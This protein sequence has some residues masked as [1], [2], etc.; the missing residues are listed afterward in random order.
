M[1]LDVSI[2]KSVG[3][4]VQGMFGLRTLLQDHASES[5]IHAITLK[6]SSL[7]EDYRAEKSTGHFAPCFTLI[8]QKGT[9][10]QLEIRAHGQ[11]DS[12]GVIPLKAKEHQGYQQLELIKEDKR[13]KRKPIKRVANGIGRSMLVLEMVDIRARLS[14]TCNDELNRFLDAKTSFEWSFDLDCNEETVS[15]VA[16][17]EN[18]RTTVLTLFF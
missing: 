8:K 17:W 5:S 13:P 6:A 16:Y 15:V 3:V 1:K 14:A 18:H 4:P 11:A 10:L 12:I 9:N 2:Q 7:Y